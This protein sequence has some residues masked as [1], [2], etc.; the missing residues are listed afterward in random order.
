MGINLNSLTV[1]ITS[2]NGPKIILPVIDSIIN[3][4]VDNADMDILII[5]DGSDFSVDRK[6]LNQYGNKVKL[7]KLEKNSG[8]C[9]ARNTGLRIAKGEL[10]LIADHDDSFFPNSLQSALDL[11][12]RQHDTQNS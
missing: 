10:V 4:T 11:L 8:V 1:V 2:Y 7:H 6:D 3:Q 12:T 5:D 9:L